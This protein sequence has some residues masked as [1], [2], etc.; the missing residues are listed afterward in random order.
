M[1]LGVVSKSFWQEFIIDTQREAREALGIPAHQD[2]DVKVIQK[3]R[4]FE[5]DSQVLNLSRTFFKTLLS[6]PS[7]LEF[8]RLD[9]AETA[10]KG[11]ESAIETYSKASYADA[12]KISSFLREEPTMQL[13]NHRVSIGRISTNKI[14]HD[15]LCHLAFAVSALFSFVIWSMQ[16]D[17]MHTA[18]LIVF[19]LSFV[20]FEV[21]K[22]IYHWGDTQKLNECYTS[23]T[24]TSSRWHPDL[25]QNRLIA[26]E[27]FNEELV[28]INYRG[29]DS[30][31]DLRY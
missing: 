26:L 15:V 31:Y 14:K 24:K 5:G 17:M 19:S 28:N 21:G 16:K 1:A 9:T 3:D 10:K 22:Q 30:G 25:C 20:I 4:V 23:L 6:D 8:T 11:L 7:Y 29:H 27:N 2:K 13:V 12:P 18:S